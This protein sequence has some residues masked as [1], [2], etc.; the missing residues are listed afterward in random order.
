M[1]MKNAAVIQNGTNSSLIKNNAATTHLVILNPFEN[2]CEIDLSFLPYSVICLEAS[3]TTQHCSFTIQQAM[4]AV[5]A[6]N[7][8]SSILSSAGAKHATLT[9]CAQILLGLGEKDMMSKSLISDFLLSKNI[10]QSLCHE[11]TTIYKHFTQVSF[12]FICFI[13]T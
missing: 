12:H 1:H 9:A 10:E 2:L 3:S 4:N 13:K 5:G 7:A 8:A 6:R 11:Y